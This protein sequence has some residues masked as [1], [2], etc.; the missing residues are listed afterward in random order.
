MK[1]F[2]ANWELIIEKWNPSWHF[3]ILFCIFFF[4]PLFRFHYWIPSFKGFLLFSFYFFFFVQFFI[5]FFRVIWKAFGRELV[6]FLWAKALTLLGIDKMARGSDKMVEIDQKFDSA[7]IKYLINL[8]P[9][10]FN[11]GKL[12]CLIHC[13]TK[14]FFRSQKLIPRLLLGKEHLR[15]TWN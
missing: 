12:K 2:F 15:I 3:N 6:V 4:Y 1:L 5:L 11:Y 14:V 9:L 13:W 8:S 7:H 10:V